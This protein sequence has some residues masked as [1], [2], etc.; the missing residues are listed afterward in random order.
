LVSGGLSMLGADIETADIAKGIYEFFGG[1]NDKEE[2]ANEA[3]AT[4]QKKDK[5]NP[6]SIQKLRETADAGR[7]IEPN[8]TQPSIDKLAKQVEKLALSLDP[9][10]SIM[11]SVKKGMK[12]IPQIMTEFDDSTLTL[13]AHDRI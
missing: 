5:P 3:T 4:I 7:A 1:K 10:K 8:S 2:I 11:G 12:E 6:E 13:M 9:K